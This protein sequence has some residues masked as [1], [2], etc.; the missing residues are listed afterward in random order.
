MRTS[1]TSNLPGA[2]SIDISPLPMGDT[3][4]RHMEI[5]STSPV[6]PLVVSSPQQLEVMSNVEE[7]VPI[8]NVD[9]ER[10]NDDHGQG[11][12]RRCGMRYGRREHERVHTSIIEPMV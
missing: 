1:H 6:V 5:P 4:I 7:L 8:A 9:Q 11:H 12:G 10:K 3:Q 2:L